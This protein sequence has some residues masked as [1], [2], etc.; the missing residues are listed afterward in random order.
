MGVEEL[1]R[2]IL[3]VRGDLG[4]EDVLRLAEEKRRLAG[5]YLS[6]EQALRVVASELGVDLGFSGVGS[7]VALRDL[8]P[9]LGD[10]SVVGRVLLVMPVRVFRR[11][12]GRLGK[13]G[14][15]LL[16]DGTSTATVVL[17][18]ERA[19]LIER[20]EVAEGAIVRVVHGYTRQSLVG[21]VEV[22]VG[23]RGEVQV[24][25]PDIKPEDFP[26]VEVG[27]VKIGEV[28][29]SMSVASVDGVVRSLGQVYT[30]TRP[31]GSQG[32]VMRL[33]I[34]DETGTVYL[35][36]DDAEG[37]SEGDGVR[38]VNARV[39]VKATGELE[40]HLDRAGFLRRLEAGL[41]PSVSLIMGITK[42][43]ELRPGLQEVDVLVEVVRVGEVRSFQR[44]GGGEGR[45]ATLIVRDDTGVVD[46]SLWDEKT[47]LVGRVK[48]GD[49]L[50]VRGA[51]TRERLG[52]VGLNLG[53]RGVV[54]VNP[55][56]PGFSGFPEVE[57]RET[58]ISEIREGRTYTVCGVVDSVPEF[59]EVSTFRGEASVASFYL[60]DDTGRIRVSLW[61]DL[62]QAAE[63]LVVGMRVRLYDLYARMGPFGL[64]LTS[65]VLSRME[66]LEGAGEK[67]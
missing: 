7:V 62:A 64:E 24:N 30:F 9:N 39:R 17:W 61:R 2:R 54:E 34:A 60:R 53:R 35:A 31:D 21:G 1:V 56:I 55:E 19:E 45:V 10:V 52:R 23:F 67:G 13:V 58:P 57:V 40:L 47:E 18:D 20:G 59:R 43:S 49:L 37:L 63:G 41:A 15:L 50:L 25:P 66:V 8:V 29:A 4:R 33:R 26:E 28:K 11:Q 12:D 5:G 46:L 38:V 44:P 16:S 48:P 3:E 36:V 32:R 6:L 51:Y 42:V 65:G 27:V 14:R 22:H